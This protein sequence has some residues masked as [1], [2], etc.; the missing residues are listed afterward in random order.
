MRDQVSPSVEADCMIRIVRRQS[1]CSTI[2]SDEYAEPMTVCSTIRGHSLNETVVLTISLSKA[3]ALF[4]P[5]Y[6]SQ[7]APRP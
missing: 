6:N 4:H 3:R 2:H 7:A 5:L 1:R